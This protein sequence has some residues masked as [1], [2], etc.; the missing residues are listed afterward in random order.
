MELL[1]EKDMTKQEITSE[2]AFDER[3]TNYYT[4]AGRYLGL[5]SK[6]NNKDGEI[7]FFLSALGNYIMTLD[8]RSRQLAIAKQI[9]EHQVF[10]QTLMPDRQ[11]VMQI[12]KNSNL[13]NLEADSTYYRRASTVIGWVNWILDTIDDL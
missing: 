1:N 5:L 8:Y 12:M 9:L 4:D 3:Q 6:G 13:Y 10:N 2:Y 11:A 7:Y